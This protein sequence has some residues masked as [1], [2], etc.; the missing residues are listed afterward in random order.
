MLN[1]HPFQRAQTGWIRENFYLEYHE[2]DLN[3]Y[4]FR[5]LKQVKKI[6]E[7]KTEIRRQKNIGRF[8]I[9]Y[10]HHMVFISMIH[11]LRQFLQ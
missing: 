9:W 6:V 2:N 7:R 1:F 10:D 5:R 4:N 11:H 3:I 8:H